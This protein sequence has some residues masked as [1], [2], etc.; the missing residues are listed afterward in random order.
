MRLHYIELILFSAYAELRA[1]RSRSYL[2]LIWWVLE[3]A[4]NMAVFYLVFGVLM[5]GQGPDYV[6][7]LLVGLTL[8]QWFK[9]SVMHA[10]YAIWQHLPLIRQVHV[11][12]HVFPIVQI[13]ADTAKFIFILAL[14][15]VILWC[16]GHPPTI[17]YLG[18]IPVLL[19]ELV[20]AAGAGYVFAAVLPLAPDLRFI[21]EQVL[22]VLMWLSGVVVAF[23]NLPPA[24]HYWLALNPVAQLIAA[25]RDILMH[26]Q[27]PD[28]AALARV[29]AI[30][31]VLLAFGSFL[32]SRLTPRYVKLPV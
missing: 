18:L 25:G 21:I 15:M 32:V 3:P 7:F 31:V 30:S 11:S 23:D 1:E 5:H 27:W 14:L 6:P 4:M 22:T 2:G 20:F 24:M 12:S 13:L 17:A 26:G 28:W 9:S 19:I 29:G 16:T 10:G 8:W